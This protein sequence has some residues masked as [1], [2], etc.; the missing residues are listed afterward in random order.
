MNELNELHMKH[1]LSVK[2]HHETIIRTGITCNKICG[3]MCDWAFRWLI[4]ENAKMLRSYVKI[5]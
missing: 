5:F 2:L 4:V 1:N 3:Y